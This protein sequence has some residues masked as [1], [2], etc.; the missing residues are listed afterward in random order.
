MD[1]EG[2]DIDS[3]IT[4][5]DG[6]FGFLVE[7][8]FYRLRAEK[9]HYQFPS[10]VLSGKGNDD[11][12]NDLYFGGLV[13]VT[14]KGGVISKNIP[15]DPIG[16]DW[17]EFAKREDNLTLWYSKYDRL[18]LRITDILFYIGFVIAALALFVALEPYNYIIF[19]LYI[20]LI[21]VRII[22]IK[23]RQYGKIIDVR[24]GRPFSYA[25]MRVLTADGGNLILKKSCDRFGRYFA[26]ISNG[27][28]IVEI[29]QKIGEDEYDTIFRSQPMEIKGGIIKREFKIT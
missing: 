24:T 28:Y 26:L 23:G 7:P 8:G 14:S 12:Y 11:V 3:V 5:L 27:T 4:D 6:R 18:V 9:T 16:F 15:L 10:N 19:G 22:G 1:T 20:L 17:N 21:V 13:E 2:N 25:V 29:D